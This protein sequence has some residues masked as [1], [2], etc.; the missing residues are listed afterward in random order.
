MIVMALRIDGK[1]TDRRR[2]LRV[3]RS[4]ASSS[5]T[6]TIGSTALARSCGDFER[7]VTTYPLDAMAE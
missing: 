5:M 1:P 6:K 2:L 4:Y 3:T 7:P